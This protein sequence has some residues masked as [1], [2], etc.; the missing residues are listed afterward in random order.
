M[1]VG[2]V[3]YGSILYTNFV[4]CI[5][6]NCFLQLTGLDF[7]FI[8]IRLLMSIIYGVSKSTCGLNIHIIMFCAF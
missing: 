3:S 8:Y 1:F 2:T 7:I 6:S 5:K 4:L